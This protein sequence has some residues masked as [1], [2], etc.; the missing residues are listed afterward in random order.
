MTLNRDGIL[1][2]ALSLLIHAGLIGL[3]N[4]DVKEQKPEP[5][6]TVRLAFQAEKEGSGLSTANEAKPGTPK[7]QD[8]PKEKPKE[9][10]AEQPKEKPQPKKK[11]TVKPEQKQAKPKKAV[12]NAAPEEKTVTKPLP[13]A[14]VTAASNQDNGTG[15]AAPASGGGIGTG[16]GSGASLGKGS[17]GGLVDVGSLKIIHKVSPEYPPFSR[18][19]GEEGRVKVIITIEDGIVTHAELEESSGFERLDSSAVEALKKWRFS[20]SGKIKARAPISFKLR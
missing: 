13:E 14:A 1:A 3:I 12:S 5:V 9:K 8:M 18:K 20:Y 16:M 7:I 4:T 17:G 6:L 19:R 15:S 10:P 11:E 2:I